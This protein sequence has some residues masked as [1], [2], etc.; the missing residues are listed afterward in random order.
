[1]LLYL[2]MEC[3]KL[4]WKGKYQDYYN[5]SY[6]YSNYFN[7]STN[8]MKKSVSFNE[9]V[10]IKYCDLSMNDKEKEKCWWNTTDYEQFRL[11]AL[12]YKLVQF[13]NSINRNFSYNYIS[14][15]NSENNSESEYSN[16][17]KNE[18]NEYKYNI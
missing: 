4:W 3:I 15:Y 1:M 13:K 6:W 2:K 9:I 7:K 18:Y 10:H 12:L 8:K 14:R 17:C 16:E 5:S 11:Y